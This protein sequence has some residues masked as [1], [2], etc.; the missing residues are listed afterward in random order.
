MEKI[1]EKTE[2]TPERA[3]KRMEIPITQQPDSHQE[4]KPETSLLQKEI[5]NIPSDL[6]CIVT[7]LECALNAQDPEIEKRAKETLHE[8]LDYANHKLRKIDNL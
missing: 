3:G 5:R 6:R 7:G 8:L 4:P 1:I 2:A